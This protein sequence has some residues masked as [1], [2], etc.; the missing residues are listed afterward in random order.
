MKSKRIKIGSRIS[1][2]K[3]IGY[4]GSSGRSTGAH[5]HYEVLRNDKQVNPM[6]IKLP[7]G[8][9]LNKKYLSAFKQKVKQVLNQKLVLEKMVENKKIAIFSKK[10]DK[11]Y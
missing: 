6:N 11:F 10:T 4:V 1:Q 5:L 2:G 3:I 8:K 9:N 7:A